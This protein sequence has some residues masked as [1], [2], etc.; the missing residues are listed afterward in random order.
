MHCDQF[1]RFSKTLHFSNIRC[2]K[3]FFAQKHSYVLIKSFFTCFLEF[4]FLTETEHFKKVI[5]LEM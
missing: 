3:G 4:Y 1:C 2:F 5:A